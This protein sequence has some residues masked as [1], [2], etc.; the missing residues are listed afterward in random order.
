VGLVRQADVDLGKGMNVSDVCRRPGISRQTSSLGGPGSLAGGSEIGRNTSRRLI[1]HCRTASFTTV[2]PPVQPCSSRRRSKIRRAVCLCFGSALPSSWRICRITRT[3]CSSFGRC[4][5]CRYPGG[6]SCAR[7]FFSV[8]QPI[9]YFPSVFPDRR[10]FAQGPC[11]HLTPNVA[12]DLHVAV[13]T[14]ASL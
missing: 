4:L 12:P 8:C 3:N 1:R 2:S 9:L 11:Q 7:I 6:S 5:A 10:P 13:H 14:C